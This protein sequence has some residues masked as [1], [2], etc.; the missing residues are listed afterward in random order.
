MTADTPTIKLTGDATGK[1]KIE[2]RNFPDI[3]KA[4]GREVLR[5]GACLFSVDVSFHFGMTLTSTISVHLSH[6][7]SIT[8]VTSTPTD[9]S[10]CARGLVHD[11]ARFVDCPCGSSRT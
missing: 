2:L 11:A 4:L 6:L 9:A 3:E 10:L 8:S 7:S 1:W 5:V